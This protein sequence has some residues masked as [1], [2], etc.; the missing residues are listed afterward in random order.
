VRTRNAVLDR[1]R[2]VALGDAR[3]QLGAAPTAWSSSCVVTRSHSPFTTI[4]RLH[5]ARGTRDTLK[6]PVTFAVLAPKPRLTVSPAT[7]VDS[8]FAGSAQPRTFVVRIGN[9]GELPLTWSGTV[10]YPWLSLSAGSELCHRKTP[11]SLTVSLT[12]AHSAPVSRREPLRSPRQ[13]PST[14]CK[15]VTVSFQDQAL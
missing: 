12:R 9:T 5:V 13:E 7:H 6:V 15:T 4:R 3:A 10:R 8:A 1:D 2:R 11:P 14:R